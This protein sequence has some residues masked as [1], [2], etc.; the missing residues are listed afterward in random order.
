MFEVLVYLFETYYAAERYP[1][2]Q[3]LTRRLTQAGF[4][5]HDI[6]EALE[7]LGQLAEAPLA[8]SRT[9]ALEN[10]R[11]MRVY[12]RSE[13]ARLTARARGFI[14]FLEYAGV[15]TPSTRELIIENAMATTLDT[16]DLED[17]KVIMLM[18][19][20]TRE[21]SVDTLVLDELLPEGG[22]RNIH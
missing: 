12:C 11:G 16:V 14:A 2:Q 13:I 10:S 5:N 4:P 18:V 7:W 20:W 8:A 19:L 22:G 9:P 6:H 21:G 1:D 15:L 3:T 17:L